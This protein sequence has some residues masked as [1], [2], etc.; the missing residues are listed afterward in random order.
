MTLLKKNNDDI[1]NPSMPFM[2]TRSYSNVLKVS[3]LKV[4][5][6]LNPSVEFRR[7][8]LAMKA[9]SRD[10]KKV[11]AKSASHSSHSCHSKQHRTPFKRDESQSSIWVKSHIELSGE[12][13]SVA[14]VCAIL[15][16]LA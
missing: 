9:E 6:S 5:A 12:V 11:V 4:G 14:E 3:R 7:Q 16:W 13:C 15:L 10:Y 2:K 8:L 1:D